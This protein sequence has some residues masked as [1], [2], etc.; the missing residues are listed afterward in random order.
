MSWEMDCLPPPGSPWYFSLFSDP[1][2]IKPGSISGCQ[3]WLE[4]TAQ[5]GGVLQLGSELIPQLRG[6]VHAE[7]RGWSPMEVPFPLHEGS[8][9]G[10]TVANKVVSLAEDVQV[11]LG[12][13]RL[14]THHLH[15]QE[16]GQGVLPGLRTKWPDPTRPAATP[17]LLSLC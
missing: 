15:L 14:Q 12:H 6:P 16:E 2:G 4:G 1:W 13:L 10:D 8:E 7:E 3:A 5:T 17:H 11:D 9:G